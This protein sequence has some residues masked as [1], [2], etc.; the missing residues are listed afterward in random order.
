MVYLNR[1][2]QALLSG[3]GNSAEEIQVPCGYS[4]KHN[5]NFT[6][7]YLESQPSACPRVCKGILFALSSRSQYLNIK[8][9]G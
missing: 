4:V 8:R 6:I 7:Q 5:G 3:K 2:H 1:T 9:Q